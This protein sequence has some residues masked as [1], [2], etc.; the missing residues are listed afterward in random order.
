MSNIFELS[1]R[2]ADLHTGLNTAF[3]TGKGSWV[4]RP[5]QPKDYLEHLEGKGSGIGIAPLRPDNTV[6]FAA[7]DMDEPDFDAAFEMQTYIPGT[8]F[9]ERSRSGNA[10]VWVYFN[11]PCEAWVAMGVLK[12]AT[13]AA[14]K[15]HI[16]IFPKNHDFSRVKLGNYINLSYHGDSR[17]ILDSAGFE[18][19]LEDFIEQAETTRNNPADWAVKARWLLLSP[20]SERV[21][22]KEFGTQE[23]LHKCAEYIISGEAGPITEGHRNAVFFMLAK[24]L[25]NWQ[26]IDYDE[27]LEILRNVNDELCE[28]PEA[29]SEIRRILRNVTQGRYTSTGCDDPLVQPFTHPDCR[30]ARS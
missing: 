29:D 16:E 4:K 1:K 19:P 26:Q 18:F 2:F 10:H 7:I 11:A 23:N 17:P 30:I 8:S 28:P 12:E 24:A 27:A 3:G 5:P 13:L 20:P 21:D 22:G 6:M 14:G 15:D 25:V 9:V